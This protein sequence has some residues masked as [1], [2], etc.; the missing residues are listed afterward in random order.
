LHPQ[1]FAIFGYA[2]V[3]WIKPHQKRIDPEDLPDAQARLD[4]YLLAHDELTR[5]GYR[6]IGMD[7]FALPDDELSKAQEKGC[8]GR[9]FMGYTPGRS[10]RIIG[11]GVSSIGD[12]GTGYF[13]NDKK[14]ANYYRSLDS[15]EFPVEKGFLMSPD[16]LL[17]RYVVHEILCNL[18]LDFGT[19][20]KRFGVRFD[21]YFAV[22]KSDLLDLAKDGLIDL[23]SD[24]LR[25]TPVGVLFLRNIAMPFD[26]Y[27]REKPPARATYSRTV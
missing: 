9:N 16:D 21:E 4:L 12:L 6:H 8:L 23:H 27:L 19:L 14:L 20:E 3:P 22:E 7:H 17:R 1:R 15:G 18:R 25:V 24:G 5:A 13:Q 10:S 26:R 2:H 11:V